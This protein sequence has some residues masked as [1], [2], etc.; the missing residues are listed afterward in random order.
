MTWA[1]QYMNW[2]QGWIWTQYIRLFLEQLILEFIRVDVEI[3]DAFDKPKSCKPWHHSGCTWTRSLLLSCQWLTKSRN[4]RLMAR[5]LGLACNQCNAKLQRKNYYNG[6]CLSCNPMHF[7]V[8]C[9]KWFA[10]KLSWYNLH[11]YVANYQSSLSEHKC[12]KTAARL[13]IV[14]LGLC[15][16]RLNLLLFIP[17]VHQGCYMLND[18]S[19]IISVSL[20]LLKW[21][22]WSYKLINHD[23]GDVYRH[24]PLLQ[25][26]R[27]YPRWL[28]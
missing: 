18:Y 9:F 16:L 7:L 24:L 22:P 27:K 26:W 14:P 20:S 6:I 3:L 4:S 15:L 23:D 12:M 28:G 5:S 1:L 10:L 25:L 11:L 21:S 2:A 8:N 19:R 17:L 13:I